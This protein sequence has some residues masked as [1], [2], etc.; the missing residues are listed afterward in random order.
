[1]LALK[2]A[3]TEL[4]FEIKGMTLILPFQNIEAGYLY[5]FINAENLAGAETSF[6][7]INKINLVGTLGSAK[8][9][10]SPGSKAMAYLGAHINTPEDLIKKSFSFGVWGAYDFN[11]NGKER[12]F[13]SSPKDDPNRKRWRAGVKASIPF[14]LGEK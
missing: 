5:D 3:A 12:D 1:M 14:G 9:I 6:W 10:D 4:K 8:S 2:A 13:L 11:A 7:R